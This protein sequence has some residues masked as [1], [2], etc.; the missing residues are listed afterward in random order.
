ML[1]PIMLLT[2]AAKLLVAAFKGLDAVKSTARDILPKFAGDAI[3]GQEQFAKAKGALAANKDNKAQKTEPFSG[4]L[5]INVNAPEGT[6]VKA[7]SQ[8]PLDFN[9]GFAGG[10]Q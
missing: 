10:I 2:N 7:K 1:N 4:V 9:L 6:N 8:G 3:F 5:D